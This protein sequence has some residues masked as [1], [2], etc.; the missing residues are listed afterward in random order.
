MTMAFKNYRFLLQHS[1][2]KE[3]QEILVEAHTFPEAA[4]LAYINSHNLKKDDGDK[5]NIVSAT[6]ESYR[7]GNNT[8]DLP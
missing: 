5:W 8:G 1:K 3:T 4:T 2:T 7:L 6:E